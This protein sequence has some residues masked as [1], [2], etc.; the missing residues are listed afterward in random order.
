[1]LQ[2]NDLKYLNVQLFIRAKESILNMQINKQIVLDADTYQKTL[3]YYLLPV[4]NILNQY[5]SLQ[6]HLTNQ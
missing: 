3:S 4:N 6:N 5:K 1:M 2:M